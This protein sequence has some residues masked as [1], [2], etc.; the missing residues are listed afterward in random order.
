VH[1]DNPLLQALSEIR[2]LPDNATA[3]GASQP[4]DKGGTDRIGA[5][6]KRTIAANSEAIAVE[7]EY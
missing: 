2:W 7:F 5:V 3:I 6:G 4:F 1:L